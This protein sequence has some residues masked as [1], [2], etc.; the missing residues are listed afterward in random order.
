ME[1]VNYTL[2]VNGEKR[3]LTMEEKVKIITRI[4]EM[5]GYRVVMRD[6]KTGK[7]EKA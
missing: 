1:K 4:A 3:G 5:Y 6:D 2:T 7:Q